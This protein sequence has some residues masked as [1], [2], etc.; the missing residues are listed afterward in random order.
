VKGHERPNEFLLESVLLS[1]K[2]ELLNVPTVQILWNIYSYR[3][4]EEVSTGL[5]GIWTHKCFFI[6]SS[7]VNDFVHLEQP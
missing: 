4:L 7:W 6:E 1:K 5:L 3:V 2:Q